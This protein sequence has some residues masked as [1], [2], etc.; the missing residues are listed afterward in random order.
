MIVIVWDENRIR[1]LKL[2]SLNRFTESKIPDTAKEERH[3]LLGDIRILWLN[4]Q[5]FL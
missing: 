5:I 4:L 2:V 3:F 1:I